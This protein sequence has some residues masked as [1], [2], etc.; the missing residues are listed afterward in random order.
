MPLREKDVRHSL[1]EVHRSIPIP[2]A[3]SFWR[4]MLAYAGPGY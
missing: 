2:N 1:P 4:K 3:K